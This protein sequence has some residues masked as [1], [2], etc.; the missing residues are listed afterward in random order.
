[1]ISDFLSS[2]QRLALYAFSNPYAET[3]LWQCV[4]NYR[5]VAM[6]STAVFD[7]VERH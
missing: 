4:P 6:S 2:T 7:L 5:T 1:M 3:V